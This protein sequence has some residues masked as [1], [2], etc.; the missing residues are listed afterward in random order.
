MLKAAGL[1]GGFFYDLSCMKKVSVITF[2]LLGLQVN[3]A[4]V[5]T[6][7]IY[8]K[9]M[10]RS[11]KT[12]VVLPEGYGASSK[13][14]PVVYLLHGAFGSYSNWIQKVPHI[15]EL[16]DRY[17]LLIVCPDGG[18]TSWYFDSPVDKNYQ[19]E[20]FVAQEVP[21]Y[22]DAHYATIAARRGRVITGLSM[23]GHGSFFVA[24]RHPAIFSAC[25]SMSG[26]FNI[27]ENKTKYD[28]I[29]RLGDTLTNRQYWENWCIP[30]MIDQ[31]PQ[32]SLAIIF[33]CGTDDGFIQTNRRV[34][35]L[36]LEH[37]IAHDYIER[38]G[39]HD[40]QYWGNAIDYQ[41]MFFRKH[42]DRVLGL[43]AS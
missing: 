27:L 35:R 39:K 4:R 18:Y 42:F 41:F 13:K 7:A 6:V 19:F 22:I 25:G 40:W 43:P 23:G 26:A 38:P 10:Q 17:Q 1:S 33:D 15:Q 34:H 36:L 14:F 3:A 31:C 28:L 12:V 21:A 16:A 24:F 2:L 29:S 9:K 8:S 32:D 5:D 20:T 37:R 11:L 30:D